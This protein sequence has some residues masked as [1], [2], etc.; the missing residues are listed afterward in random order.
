MYCNAARKIAE[1][2]KAKIL[3]NMDAK[4]MIPMVLLNYWEAFQRVTP[5]KPM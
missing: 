5:M 1:K 4:D 2:K 3:V